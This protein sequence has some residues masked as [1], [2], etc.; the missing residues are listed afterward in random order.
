MQETAVVK[1]DA[2]KKNPD[3]SWTCVT[4]TDIKKAGRIIRINP[5]MTFRK[6]YPQW[7]IDVVGLL[8]QTSAQE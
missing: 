7:G 3:G 1:P 6:E 2:F 4:N 8:E 5:G